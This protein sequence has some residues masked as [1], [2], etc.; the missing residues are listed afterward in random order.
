MA[1]RRVSTDAFTA[2]EMA[3]TQMI[4]E[5]HQVGLAIEGAIDAL[6]RYELSVLI[7]LTARFADICEQADIDPENAFTQLLRG[8]Q[9]GEFEPFTEEFIHAPSNTK[10]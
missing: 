2:D 8:V 5:A 1:R 9:A 7:A 10:H 3:D 4:H 6:P